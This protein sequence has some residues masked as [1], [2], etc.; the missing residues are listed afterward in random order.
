MIAIIVKGFH[1]LVCFA[2]IIIVLFQADKGE[3]LAGA[4]GGGASSTIFGER[5][6]ATE[7]SKLT[8]A[9]AIIFMVTS[10]IIAFWGPGWE[11]EADFNRSYNSQP[12]TATPAPVAPQT[13]APVT[14]A[15]VP[16]MPMATPITDP[17]PITATPAP[18][19][20]PAPVAATPAPVETPAPVAA[21]PA[22]VETPAPAAATP[23]PVETPA[24]AAATLAPVETPAPAAATPAPVET[25][26]PVVEETKPAE[27]SVVPTVKEEINAVVNQEKEKAVDALKT[28]VEEK[29][30]EAVE[31]IKEK[32]ENK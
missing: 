26:A 4:F 29:K 10:S 17:T 24:P 1:I 25:P 8:T 5:G 30:S 23:A 22:P 27:T 14:G 6:G 7:I 21:T 28:I 20:T 2:L 9:L 13:Q 32:I 16:T 3:G 31:A 12:I 15:A 18:V 11:K 19:E